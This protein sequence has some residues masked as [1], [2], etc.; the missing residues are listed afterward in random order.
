[1]PHTSFGGLMRIQ[2]KILAVCLLLLTGIFLAPN[3]AEAQGITTGNITGTVVDPQ[4]AVVPGATVT[5]TEASKGS[6]NVT[7]SRPNGTFSFPDMPTG[8][9][10][11]HVDATGFQGYDVKGVIVAVGSNVNLHSLTMQVGGA[12]QT[13]N[14]VDANQV[15]LDTT[16]SQVSTVFSPEE[17][18]QLPLAN[19]FDTVALLAPG[20][21]RTLMDNFSNTNGPG[22]S[23]NGQRGRANNFEVDGQANNDNSI[24]GPAIFMGNQDLL[25]GI[26]VITNQFG[27]EYGRNMGSVVNYQ[28]KSGTNSFHG[29]AF[30]FYTG[31]W[32]S[33]LSQQ[34]KSPVFGFCPPGVSPTTGCAPVNNPKL[35]DNRWGATLGGPVLRNKLWFFGSGYWV[36]TYTGTIPSTSGSSLTPTPAGIAQLAGLF[37]NAPAVGVLKNYGPYSVTTGSPN[38]VAS[39]ASTFPVTPPGSTTPVDVP[40]APISRT[41][42]SPFL[43]REY[44]GRLDWQPD[45]ADRFFARLYYQNDVSSGDGGSTLVSQGAWYDVP[46]TNWLIGAN[47]TRT[48]SSRWVNS[49]TYGFQEEKLLFQSGGLSDCVVTQFTACTSSMNFNGSQADLGFGYATNLPQGRTIKVTQVQD[50]ATFSTGRNTILFGGEVDYQNSPNFFLPDYNGQYSFGSLNALMNN[51]A[52]TVS[53]ANGN[54][55]IPFTEV[56]YFSY[57]E[58]DWKIMDTLTLNMGLRWEIYGMAIN[59]LHA[60]TLAQQTG[61]NPFWDT[62][63][64]LSLTTQASIPT[65]YKNFEPRLGFNWNPRAMNQKLSVQGGFAINFD[66]I[67]YNPFLNVAT[68]AP[69]VFAA[70]FAPTGPSLPSNGE[71]SGAAVRAAELPNLPT[72]GDPGYDNIGLVSPN[73][74]NPYTESYRLGVQYQLTPTSLVTASY[75][76]NH[77]VG[78]FQNINANPNLGPV[79]AV[80]PNIVNPSSLCTTP[81]TPGTFD[82]T[83]G[84]Q[85]PLVGRPDCSRSVVNAT[86]NTAFA[87]YNGLQLQFQKRTSS[88]LIF[89]ANYTYSRTI[90]NASEIYSTFGG[91]NTNAYAQNPQNIDQGER[92]LSGLSLTHVVAVDTVYESPFFRNQENW[93]GKL[94]GG[95]TFSAIW[96]ANSGEPYQPLQTATFTN[97][98][99]GNPETSFC[100]T[101][102]DFAE[103]GADNCRMVLSNPKAP[104]QSVAYNAGPTNGYLAFE[105]G[106]AFGSTGVPLNPAN[107]HWIVDNEAQAIAM[108][109]PYPGSSR[110]ILRGDMFN[111]LDASVYKQ[112]NLSHGVVLT[113]QMNV[114]N[115]TNYNFLNVPNPYLAAYSPTG[116]Q[117]FL[118]NYFNS[119]AGTS[120]SSQ[121]NRQVQL[122]GHIVF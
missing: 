72:G 122:E 94:L 31:S 108:G 22:F 12:A 14:V 16:N 120:Y 115:A 42:A 32:G 82:P 57:I 9:Y 116:T 77:Q 38:P 76:G 50:N 88:G 114:Y 70:S 96:T 51:S 100:D 66:P 60:S 5:A 27:A 109:N 59:K 7:Q 113:L 20:T 119:S 80:F 69:D 58:D 24:A 33:A 81:N 17:L 84:L 18:Q 19:S 68:A 2:S 48:F 86:T 101:G 11:I 43:D 99:T 61:S 87:L 53:L 121:G 117:G 89:T 85:G 79:A 83:G 35:V 98:V 52:S 49:L 10:N 37:P 21:A 55:V 23:S 75:N 93:K 13:V 74:H 40:V 64:P 67:F 45:N 6:S 3:R 90:D 41:V 15:E 26:Q 103:I 112:T 73:F 34:Y 78:N 29:S 63:L 110:N 97:P 111:E 1:M 28:T 4:G 46:D 56:D 118:T 91:G 104:L 71:F 39:G 106:P 36:H 62:S 107:A 105:T 44:S 65:P 47:W 25:S 8:V 54:P 102:F 30:E 95:Y 92:A